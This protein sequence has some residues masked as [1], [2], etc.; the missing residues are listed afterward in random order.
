MFVSGVAGKGYWI[1]DLLGVGC[2]NEASSSLG[3]L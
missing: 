1:A 2:A 3:K